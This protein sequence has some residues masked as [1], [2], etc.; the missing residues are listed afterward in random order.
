MMRP[1]A[2]MQHNK[3]Q[4][5]QQAV[6]CTACPRL[7][8]VRR[9][10]DTVPG[11]GSGFCRSGWLPVLARAAAHFGEEPCI[12][13]T[14][15]SGAVFFS[16]CSLRCVFCQNESISRRYCGQQVTVSRLREIFI[17]LSDSGI[18]NI[19][20]VNPTHFAGAIADALEQPLPVPVVYNSSGY[21]RVETLRRLEGKIQVYMPDYKYALAEPAA[22]Y[23]AAGDYPDTA[24]AAIEEMYRQCGRYRL[25]GEG[26]LQSG[27]L[28][29][30][31]V[32]PGC[33]ENTR[34]VID[35]ITG[36]FASGEVLFS[37]MGQ[38]TPCG[39]LSRFPELQYPLSA[40]EYAEAE[41]YLLATGWEDG[42]LQPP[43]AAGVEHIPAF[44]LTGVRRK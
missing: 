10:E 24:W 17:E 32:L 11:S 7:C 34:R 2:E 26:I 36:N 37:L 5:Q 28:I 20:L 27:V 22:R 41:E 43:E 14:R 35:R 18:H 19:N 31:L 23:S 6:L 4:D 25:D 38:Y 1:S 12:S 16:G 13:G 9:G 8:G 15:G 40:L 39:D 30:H 33:A 44:D 3:M 42:Y 21:E 29:R